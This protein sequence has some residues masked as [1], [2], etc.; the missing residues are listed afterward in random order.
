MSFCLKT[1]LY[2]VLLFSVYFLT[3]TKKCVARKELRTE[4]MCNS[5]AATQNYKITLKSFLHAKNA[6]L[7]K[8]YVLFKVI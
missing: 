2:A 3:D 7:P 8:E 4:E 5:L 1:Q 6:L